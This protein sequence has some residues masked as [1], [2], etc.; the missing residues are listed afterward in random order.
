[1]EGRSKIYY[2]NRVAYIYMDLVW[3]RH[4][5]GRRIGE[6]KREQTH[7]LHLLFTSPT[8]IAAGAHGLF[9]TSGRTT[10]ARASLRM[11]GPFIA[12]HYDKSCG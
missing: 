5:G 3:S 7:R 11:L 1:M 8:S 9:H 2:Y 4:A 6:Q 10:S 12:V